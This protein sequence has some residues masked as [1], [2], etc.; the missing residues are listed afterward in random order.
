MI[1]SIIYDARGGTGREGQEWIYEVLDWNEET[2]GKKWFPMFL[3]NLYKK[4]SISKI[5]YKHYSRPGH[6]RHYRLR[7]GHLRRAPVHVLPAP[8]APGPGGQVGGKEEREG[9]K[10]G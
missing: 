3:R 10:G 9:R 4:Y 8:A 6:R 7:P 1:F 5:F 2:G